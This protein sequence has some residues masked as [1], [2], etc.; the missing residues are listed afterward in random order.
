MQEK[1]ENF[2]LS[3][4]CVFMKYFSCKNMLTYAVLR[5]AT[6][7]VLGCMKFRMLFKRIDFTPLHCASLQHT[8]NYFSFP[9]LINNTHI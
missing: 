3:D 4:K 7:A 6:V 2:H 8:Y 1:L 5:T 9:G